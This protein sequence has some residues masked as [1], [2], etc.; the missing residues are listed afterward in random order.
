[1]EGDWRRAERPGEYQPRVW[2]ASERADPHHRMAE[3]NDRF[4]PE[5]DEEGRHRM[6]ARDVGLR[7]REARVCRQELMGTRRSE[8][9]SR[10]A[11]FARQWLI[12]IAPG[13]GR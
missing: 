5:A 7:E 11:M 13:T 3:D 8:K 2:A 12:H 6:D 10:R 9:I 4:R 1:M